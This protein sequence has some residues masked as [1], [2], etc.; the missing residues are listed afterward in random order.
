MNKYIKTELTNKRFIT[1]AFL[2]IIIKNMNFKKN[3]YNP[4][5]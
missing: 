2:K 4:S 5:R 3:K 1:S